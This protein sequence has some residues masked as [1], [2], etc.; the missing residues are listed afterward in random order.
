MTPTTIIHD[1]SQFHLHFQELD[2]SSIVCCR[3]RL[4]PGEEHILVDLQHRGVTLIPS[5]TSQLASRSKV[6]Q[7]R[8]FRDYMLPD[9]L[10]VYD[11]NQLLA[12]TSTYRQRN[13]GEV[14]VKQDRR[15][16]GTGIHRFRDIEDVYNQAG[17]GPLTFPLVLQPLVKEFR[18]IRLIILG[19]YIEAYERLNPCNFRHNL[20]CGG[21]ARSIRPDEGLIDFCRQVMAR[22]DFPYGHLDLMLM[23]GGVYL[24]EINLRGGLRGA[25]IDSVAYRGAIDRLHEQLL[26]KKIHRGQQSTPNPP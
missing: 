20:H 23:D 4:L 3:L 24:T 10:A 16:G 8:I 1:N 21:H 7:A 9:T 12:A 11:N 2:S 25:A 17:V 5:A 26:K 22:G 14:V 18:D 6:H 13:I 19:D 15:N